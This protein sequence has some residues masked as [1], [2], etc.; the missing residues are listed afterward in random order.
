LEVRQ[1]IDCL[2][3][4][5]EHALNTLK[6]D[7][8]A[9]GEEGEGE[10][11]GMDGMT[12]YNVTLVIQK[13]VAFV[14]HLYDVGTRKFGDSTALPN[15]VM[16]TQV[17]RPTSKAHIHIYTHTHMKTQV[18]HPTSKAHVSPSTYSSI[19]APARGNR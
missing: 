10:S 2:V 12:Q 11:F 3:E 16:K 15:R 6:V 8:P 13:L 7:A 17:L 14:S 1:L 18:L 5:A 9:E 19:P 4:E